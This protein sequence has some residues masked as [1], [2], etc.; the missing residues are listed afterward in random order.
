MQGD[1]RSLRQVH[2]KIILWQN[3]FSPLSPLLNW[4]NLILKGCLKQHHSLFYHSKR[5][6]H[7]SGLRLILNLTP[8]KTCWLSTLPS[9]MRW[10]KID[11]DGDDDSDDD[12]YDGGDEDHLKKRF[13]FCWR[14]HPPWF[15]FNT[16][17]DRFKTSP[18]EERSR[19]L[20]MISAKVEIVFCQKRSER[21]EGSPRLLCPAS[22]RRMATRSGKSKPMICIW[23]ITWN[24][25]K[26][27]VETNS[28][29]CSYRTQDGQKRR[30][31]GKVKRSPKKDFTSVCFRWILVRWWPEVVGSTLATTAD[32]TRW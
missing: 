31:K 13:I 4:I 15:I 25:L 5:S 22:E 16:F 3:I 27:K 28:I 19:L 12:G 18:V 21:D 14:F 20:P 1:V 30:E 7:R 17:P 32:S 2:F 11:D 24:P 23:P 10:P 29:C 6:F 9:V 8:M 26:W